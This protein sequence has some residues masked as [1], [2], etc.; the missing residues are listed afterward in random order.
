MGKRMADINTGMC[1]KQVLYGDSYWKLL[2]HW[3]CFTG[4]TEIHFNQSQMQDYQMNNELLLYAKQ[5]IPFIY[6]LKV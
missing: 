5:M 1:V 2:K 3:I 4:C 6:K